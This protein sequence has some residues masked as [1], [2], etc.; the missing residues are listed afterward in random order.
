VCREIAVIKLDVPLYR[1]HDGD[2]AKL[3]NSTV[4]QIKK[5]RLPARARK[6]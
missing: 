5:S 1:P 4:D 6:K 2:A 3:E